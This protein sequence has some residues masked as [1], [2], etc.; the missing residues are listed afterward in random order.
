ME[1][2]LVNT[3]KQ[4]CAV[5]FTITTD[6]SEVPI[7]IIGYDPINKNTL[8][9]RSRF[10]I[11]GSEEITLNCPQ[12]P[13]LLKI[14]VWSEDD[15]PFQLPSVRL[16]PLEVIKTDDPVIKWIEYFSR[17]AGRLRPGNYVGDNVPFT[18]QVKR[19]I[20]TDTGEV[21]PTP[22]RIHTELPIIQVSKAKFDQ[23]TVPERVIILLHEFA[24]NFINNDQ[25]NEQ[26]SDQHALNIYN[27]LGY[28][29]IEAVNA[30]GDIMADTDDNYQRMLNLV[31]M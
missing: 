29:K 8:Y 14:I 25:D 2:Y 11:S 22:A 12:S 5:N 1:R 7:Y 23:N 17:V 28:P 15:L 30:F 6:G 26:E 3:K 20:Y 10:L 19:N 18:I 21:H 27:E 31:N 9:F 4:P 13:R 24:H 16:L